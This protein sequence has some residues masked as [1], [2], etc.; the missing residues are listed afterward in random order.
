[1][2]EHNGVP[3][4][5]NARMFANGELEQLVLDALSSTERLGV[6]DICSRMHV[7]TQ[8][9]SVVKVLTRLFHQGRI[10][11]SGTRNSYRYWSAGSPP[12]PQ[13]PAAPSTSEPARTAIP[14][15]PPAPPVQQDVIQLGRYLLQPDAWRV[16]D[17]GVPDQITIYLSTDPR[18]LQFSRR[19]EPDLYYAACRWADGLTPA[20]LDTGE[21]EQLQ[22]RIDAAQ[23]REAEALTLAEQYAKE[24]DVLK[25]ELEGLKAD[26]AKLL[27]LLQSRLSG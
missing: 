6:H 3:R 7:S 20:P 19:E 11:R 27:A 17:R 14:Q 21:R 22:A 5:K 24:L 10:Q 8:N 15:V 13:E 26:P 16:I 1:M 2:A 18:R 4:R 23:A 9:N 12:L 25:Q